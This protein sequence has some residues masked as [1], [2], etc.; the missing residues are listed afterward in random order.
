MTKYV[1]IINILILTVMAVSLMSGSAHALFGRVAE[2]AMK[3]TIQYTAK[4][5]GI[6]L[7]SESGELFAK[8]AGQ[9]IARHGDDGIRALRKAGPD[10]IEL[11]AR[12]GSDAVRV[13]ATHSDSAARYLAKNM[14]LALP[15]WRKFGK[16]G[17]ELMVRHPGFAEPLLK[18]FG[19]KGLRVGEKLS[20]ESL[21]RF[22]ILSSKAVSK[23]EKA[24]LLDDVLKWGDEILE[25][26][27]RHKLKIGAGAS[28]YALLKEYKNGMV[29]D[30]IGPDG[31]VNQ[32]TR[33]NTLGQYL[34]A[35]ILDKLLNKYPWILL[36]LL[37]LII[38]WVWPLLKYLWAFPQK[39]KAVFLKFKIK[40]EP[41][42]QS[43]IVQRHVE[44]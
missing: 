2:K 42:K 36:I 34:S 4:K 13:C 39:I 14:D 38:L 15:V 43:V 10:I 3:E 28:L 8:K 16:R 35:K 30:Q 32:R 20:S 19:K 29:I 17:T 23:K 44:S 6:N 7:F 11:S 31:K 26:L 25:F 5:F 18:Q 37:M 1:K 24:V 21:E 41:S 22:L 12:H 27:W 33:T 9:F 40:K